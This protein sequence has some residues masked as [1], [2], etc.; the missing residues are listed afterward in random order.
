M[1]QRRLGSSSK[2][3]EKDLVLSVEFKKGKKSRGKK[4]LKYSNLSH[5]QC[6]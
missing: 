5:I 4:P 3:G 2:A 1:L 6:F